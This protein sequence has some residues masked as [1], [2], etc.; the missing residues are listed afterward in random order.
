MNK[1]EFMR[2]KPILPLLLSMGVPMMISMLIHS[3]T[4]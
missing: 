4:V 2:T 1:Q 3:V